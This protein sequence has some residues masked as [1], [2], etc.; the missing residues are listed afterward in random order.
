LFFSSCFR[1]IS[2]TGKDEN[3]GER[4]ARPVPVDVKILSAET[5]ENE[6]FLNGSVLADEEI[7]LR[8]E[9]S[10]RVIEINFREGRPVK[11]GDTLV[12][13][14]DSELQ[15]QLRQAQTRLKFLKNREFRAK[16]LLAKKGISEEEYEQAL[17]EF[18]T[19][20]AQID[21][22]QAQIE[23]TKIIAPFSGIIGLRHI[24]EGAYIGPDRVVASLQKTDRLKIE[25]DAPQRY[26]NVIKPGAKISFKTPLSSDSK[27]AE[28]YAV[29]PKITPATRSIAARAIFPNPGSGIIPGAYVEIELLA[30]RDD[31]ALMIPTNALIPDI[32]GEQ[33]YLYKSGKVVPR[34]VKAGLRTESE[35]QLIEGVSPGDTVIVS[36]IIQLRPGSDVTIREAS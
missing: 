23:K 12:K 30:G 35:V 31:S 18:E 28:I 15:A 8:S 6:I 13:I 36:G 11:K 33:V 1:K 20:A 4:V 9:T 10:G 7:E 32:S 17:N 26:I 5:A 24:S 22:L 3:G 21:Y 34:N 19:Q 29:E 27:T 16:E 25:F 2:F 14:N